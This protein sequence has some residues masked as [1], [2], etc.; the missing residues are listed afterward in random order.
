MFIAEKKHDTSKMQFF[1]LNLV[2]HINISSFETVN[3]MDVEVLGV[4]K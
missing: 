3:E 1:V 4:C 2:V